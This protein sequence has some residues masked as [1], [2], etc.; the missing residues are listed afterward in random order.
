MGGE[1]DMTNRK[2]R[3]GFTLLELLVVLVI[4]S[5]VSTIG[6]KAFTKM[7]TLWGDSAARM[8]VDAKCATIFDTMRQDME[9]VASAQRTGYSIQGVDHLEIEHQVNRHKPEDD[10]IVLPVRQ[11]SH[12]TGFW[13]ELAVRYHISRDGA[14]FGLMRTVGPNDGTTPSNA[15]QLID[16]QVIAMN[17][18]YLDADNTWQKEWSQSE[19]PTAVRVSLTVSLPNRPYDQVSR[20]AVFPIHVR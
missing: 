12:G 10:S 1:I 11:R 18:V 8:E 6:V 14:A 16:E 7:V 19:L 20:E 4:L 17:I 9:R 5:V 3:Y 2:K 15:S 13:E